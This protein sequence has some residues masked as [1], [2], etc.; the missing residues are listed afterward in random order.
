MNGS[1]SAS[2]RNVLECAICDA[3][4]VP[5]D[6]RRPSG[7]GTAHSECCRPDGALGEVDFPDRVRLSIHDRELLGTVAGSAF[8][9]GT[10][11]V[12]IELDSILPRGAT[13]VIDIETSRTP[14]GW[15]SP[16]GRE[17]IHTGQHIDHGRV[18]IE[19]AD[20]IH[21][22][23]DH[24]FT[25]ESEDHQVDNESSAYEQRSVEV[26]NLFQWF[27]DMEITQRQIASETLTTETTVSEWANGKAVPRPANMD[28]LRSL[29]DRLRGEETDE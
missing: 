18:S 22:A 13:D 17:Y 19:R 3:P 10:Y 16:V 29:Q 7:T 20:D 14:A 5:G 21:Q 11:A 26:A 9:R 25:G 28:K 8:V 23:E 24:Q 1:E 6:R 2:N 27:R 4:I 15:S 12:R